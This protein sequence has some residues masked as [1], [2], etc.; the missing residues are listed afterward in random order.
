[1]MHIVSSPET[2]WCWVASRLILTVDLA[3]HSD[4]DVLLHILC[5][6]LLGWGGGSGGHWPALPDTDAAYE[7]IDSRVL[8]RATEQRIPAKTSLVIA[9]V[10]GVSIE[11]KT[12]RD[13]T[14]HQRFEKFELGI[15]VVF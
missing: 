3:A 9:R 10:N 5:N 13:Y 2:G 7:N 15:G 12:K 14:T 11:R 4:G 8:L 6:G 1:M